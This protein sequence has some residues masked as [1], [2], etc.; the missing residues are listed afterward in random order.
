MLA[1][2]Y[3]GQRFRQLTIL[4]INYLPHGGQFSLKDFSSGI[5]AVAKA[6]A[7]NLP[8]M[9]LP[10]HMEHT[11]ANLLKQFFSHFEL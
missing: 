7:I 2:G 3:P 4:L 5:R 6:A 8:N 9:E 11:F 1:P 10:I